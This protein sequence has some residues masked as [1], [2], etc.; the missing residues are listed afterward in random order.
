MRRS[1]VGRCSWQQLGGHGFQGQKQAGAVFA[2]HGLPLLAGECGFQR[3]QQV[4][5]GCRLAAFDAHV[6]SHRT[7]LAQVVQS[8]DACLLQHLNRA[9][10]EPRQGGERLGWS[11]FHVKH[12]GCR[13]VALWWCRSDQGVADKI[14]P[15]LPWCLLLL[16]LQHPPCA[17]GCVRRMLPVVVVGVVAHAVSGFV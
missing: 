16:I 1:R 7:Q 15:P 13:G 12:G 9:W 10:T 2:C 3:P 11:L 17:V 5:A 4:Q 14:R 8:V 6:G